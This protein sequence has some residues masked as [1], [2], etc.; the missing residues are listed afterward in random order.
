MKLSDFDFDL[1][2]DL[3]ALRPARP[4]SSA[5]LLLVRDEEFCDTRVN[6]LPEILRPGDLLVV[7]DTKV[8]PGALDGHRIRESKSKISLNLVQDLG[9]GRWRALAK[10]LRRIRSGDRLEFGNKLWATVIERSDSG[11]EICFNV[12]GDAFDRALS[13]RG[14]APLPPYISS[15]RNIDRYDRTDYQTIFAERPGAV[16]APTASLHFDNALRNNLSDNGI[17]IAAITLHV[18]EGTFLPVKSE[19][20][21]EH[22]MHAEWGEITTAAAE[23]INAV[24]DAGGRIVAVGTTPLRLLES[25]SGPRGELNAWSGETRIFIKPGYRVRSVDA[26]LT[27]FHLPKST[28]FILVAALAGQERVRSIYRH[29][30]SERYRFYSYGDCMLLF[31]SGI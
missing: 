17:G 23:K 5:R 1:P 18:G 19:S 4:R 20:I 7:N 6:R 15:R 12:K 11:I 25:A 9:C 21:G 28:L 24:R 27:N 2:D 3:I 13:D 26:L 8:V 22:R 10:P 14:K 29:A 31:L 16:A 30:V